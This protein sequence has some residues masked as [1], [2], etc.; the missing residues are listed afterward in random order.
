MKPKR[1]KIQ[2][3]IRNIDVSDLAGDIDLTISYLENLQNNNGAEYLD[4]EHYPFSDET[5]LVA[6]KSR[7][8][9]D[10]EYN[11]RIT[12]NKAANLAEKQR[13]EKKKQQAKEDLIKQA[14]KL[15]LEI[16]DSWE[17]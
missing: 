12:K 15:K 6:Y 11:A 16:P 2:E 10:E 5:H 13:K 3:R 9:T 14:K 17:K 4:I 1:L 8:E 7:E